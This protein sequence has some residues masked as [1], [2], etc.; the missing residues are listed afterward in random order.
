MCVLELSKVSVNNGWIQK[1]ILQ[2][3]NANKS[4]LLFTDTDNMVYETETESFYDD[5]NK[6]KEMFD[7]S[8]CSAKSRYY[9]GSWNG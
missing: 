9:D 1:Q 2:K 8:I 7:V 5:F 6:N 3:K 4:R